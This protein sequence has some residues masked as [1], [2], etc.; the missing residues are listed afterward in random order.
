MQAGKE[1]GKEG[2]KERGKEKTC[3]RRLFQKGRRV[4]KAGD[5]EVRKKARKSMKITMTFVKENAK[6]SDKERTIEWSE[7]GPRLRNMWW[8][9]EAGT[10][11]DRQG[12]GSI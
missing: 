1:G 10:F 6:G 5:G 4:K 2:R 8:E 12:G 7:R 9:G 11:N 3:E